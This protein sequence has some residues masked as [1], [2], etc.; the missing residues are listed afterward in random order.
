MHVFLLLP[1]L[2][3]MIPLLV[4]HISNVRSKSRKVLGLIFR[5]FYHFSSPNTILN[6]YSS[7]VHSILEY[8]SP[9][10]F[11]N[12]VSTSNS[13]ES[14]Q[15]FAL[16]IASKFYSPASSLLTLP[17]LSSRRLQARIKLLFAITCNLYFLPSPIVFLQACPPYPIHS[18]HPSN[19]SLI[20]CQPSFFSKSFFPST[21]MIWNSLL[22]LL[23]NDSVLLSSLSLS[24]LLL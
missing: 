19:L 23:Q 10:W 2:H 20:F 11:P 14:I 22:P 12:S 16:R 9:V 17:S 3:Y 6:L 4:P 21:I 15:S 7:L 18:Y 1:Q 24:I 8:C 13:L 5:L